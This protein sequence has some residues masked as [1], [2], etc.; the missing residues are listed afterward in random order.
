MT[1]VPG[2][3]DAGGPI[4][5]TGLDRSGKTTMRAFLASHSRIAIPAVGS[6]MWMYF[7]RRY[8]DLGRDENLDRCLRAMMRYKHVRFLD[9]EEARIREEFAR[10]EATYPRLFAIFLSQFAERE[11]KPRWGA[12]SGLEEQY[13]EQMFDA[14]PG[15]K[16]IHMLRDPRDRYEASLAKWPDGRGRAGGAAARWRFSADLAETNLRRH[17]ADYLVVRFEDLILD[18]ARTVR[19]VCD[20]LGEEFEPAMLELAAAPK[21]RQTLGIPEGS[22]RVNLSPEF[23]GLHS[24]RVPRREVAFM[25]VVL[26]SRMRR[27]GYDVGPR[28]SIVHDAAWWV[29][30]VPD[31][32]AR[33]MAWH[34]TE[35]MHH[36]FPRYL[37]RTPG[38]RMILAG[39]RT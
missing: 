14:Y 1:G 17:P 11:G 19:E 26:G 35:Q 21:H 28:P 34:V 39:D 3:V 8:G 37:G 7:Y 18:T 16:M 31:Q 2:G 6:N 13:A 33:M 32:A 29:S 10:G 9:P 22:S 30:V 20:F 4:Y 25:D 23:I 5:I 15:L 38:A 36:R 24:E 12:Q 27:W